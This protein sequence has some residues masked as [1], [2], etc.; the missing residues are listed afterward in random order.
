M[1]TMPMTRFDEFW[2]ALVT[3]VSS[4]LFSEKQFQQVKFRIHTWRKSES[5]GFDEVTLSG[6]NMWS[7]KNPSSPFELLCNGQR[8]LSDELLGKDELELVFD[9]Q[10]FTLQIL[11]KRVPYGNPHSFRY[12]FEHT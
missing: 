3:D 11:L 7:D 5:S 4:A 10:D 6:G 1:N 2:R 8:I 9:L 12:L